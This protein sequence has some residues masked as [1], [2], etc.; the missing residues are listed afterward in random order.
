MK[1]EELTR[2]IIA[3]ALYIVGFLMLEYWFGDWRMG[4]VILAFITANNLEKTK[5]L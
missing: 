4:V 1:K 2:M 3:W 5:F